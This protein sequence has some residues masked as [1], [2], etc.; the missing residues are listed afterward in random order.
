MA[1]LLLASRGCWAVLGQG[2]ALELGN[3]KCTSFLCLPW[4][5]RARHSRDS[6]PQP[7]RLKMERG[8][9]TPRRA[10]ANPWM[11]NITPLFGWENG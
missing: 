3:A 6:D 7:P 2:P 10:V 1:P 8:R 11:G 9:H 5:T 4:G